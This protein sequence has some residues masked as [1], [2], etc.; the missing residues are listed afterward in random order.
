MARS[1]YIW[2][3]LRNLKFKFH[4]HSYIQNTLN[5]K[6]TLTLILTRTRTRKHRTMIFR[7]WP[8]PGV[9]VDEPRG[10]RMSKLSRGE[11]R[12]G[13]VMVPTGTHVPVSVTS[14]RLNP[15]LLQSTCHTSSCFVFETDKVRFR[16]I[17]G[18][19]HKQKKICNLSLWKI[20]FF[21]SRANL[22]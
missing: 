12:N 21:K 2:T 7:S 4:S 20:T 10:V 6:L 5:F 1:A 14:V 8:L 9:L 19:G 3:S 15:S 22:I 18:R 11:R 16:R 13:D 17:L